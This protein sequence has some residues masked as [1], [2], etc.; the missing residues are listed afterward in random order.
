M[1]DSDEAWL[2]DL[3]SVRADVKGG[4]QALQ[5]LPH[6]LEVG[7]SNTPG[8][9]YQQDEVSLHP[10]PALERLVRGSTWTRTVPMRGEGK[11]EVFTNIKHLIVSEIQH[12]KQFYHKM[13]H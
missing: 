12:M 4:D 6:L 1:K 9:I 10:G 8:A 13:N 3:H 2:T 5:E 11:T 7:A